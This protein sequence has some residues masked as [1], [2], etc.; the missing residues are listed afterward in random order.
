[1][2]LRVFHHVPHARVER[3]CLRRAAHVGFTPHA[4]HAH[5]QRASSR[6]APRTCTPAPSHGPNLN[7]QSTRPSSRGNFLTFRTPQIW[8][9]VG[10]HRALHFCISSWFGRP[11]RR[12][13]ARRR[14]KKRRRRSLPPHT[15]WVRSPSLRATHTVEWQHI[16]L[17][18]TVRCVGPHAM[19][20]SVRV[21]TAGGGE[22]VGC[23][24]VRIAVVADSIA[25]LRARQCGQAARVL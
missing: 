18:R 21:R 19:R 13:P 25:P 24:C 9:G 4:P 12:W 10:P 2:R 5:R 22:E 16:R 15:G 6:F 17:I 23:V 3:R 20:F 8:V 1:M 7:A 11:G 14:P